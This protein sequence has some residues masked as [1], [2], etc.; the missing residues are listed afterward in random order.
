MS[1]SSCS[2]QRGPA[3]LI[4]GIDVSAEKEQA[5]TAAL[6][7]E[8][9]ALISGVTRPHPGS[10]STKLTSAPST[11]TSL[12][13]AATSPTDAL[14]SSSCPASC[15]FP[16]PEAITPRIFGAV[17]SVNL[18]RGFLG[19]FVASSSSSSPS[20]KPEKEFTPNSF[21]LASSAET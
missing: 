15:F 21:S 6:D 18:V 9:A 16:L 13:I 4:R 12:R 17:A 2:M 1:L 7:P 5:I 10:E 14:S 20:S 11:P 19:R 8:V 3:I